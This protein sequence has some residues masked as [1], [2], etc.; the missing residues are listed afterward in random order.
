MADRRGVDIDDIVQE[1]RQNAI[2][3]RPRS[4]YA[5]TYQ[6]PILSDVITQYPDRTAAATRRQRSRLVDLEKDD[7]ARKQQGLP[8]R[9]TAETRKYRGQGDQMEM[10]FSD[11]FGLGALKR[12]VRE[13]GLKREAEVAEYLRNLELE[14]LADADALERKRLEMLERLTKMDPDKLSGGG[15]PGLYANIAAKRRRIKAGSGE[16]MRSPGSKGAPTKENFRQAE[17]TAKK[18]AG[19][20]LNYSKGYYGKS[21]K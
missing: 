16:K 3:T 10:D 19:G 6:N 20:A 1:L 4:R 7:L 13:A 21:Y 11:E 14:K 5:D 15:R 18:A 12:E 17:T 8:L 9:D 2:P